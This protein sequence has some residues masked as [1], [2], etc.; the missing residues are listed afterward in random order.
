MDLRICADG[1]AQLRGEDLDGARGSADDHPQ[2]AHAGDLHD[3]LL[4]AAAEGEVGRHLRLEYVDY[5]GVHPVLLAFVFQ[6]PV[7]AEHR[8]LHVLVGCFLNGPFLQQDPGHDFV[9]SHRY[10]VVVLPVEHPEQS[11]GVAEGR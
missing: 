11:F 10:V 3:V 8:V 6:L 4:D 5:Y 7:R 9:H 2:V 1:F